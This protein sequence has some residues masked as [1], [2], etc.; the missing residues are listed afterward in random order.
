MEAFTI[1]YSNKSVAIV[2]CR[3]S[4]IPDVERGIMSLES[5]EFAIKEFLRALKMQVYS[6]LKTVGSAYNKPQPDLLNALS[7]S[8]NKVLVVYE[9]NRLT[10]NL[11]TYEEI[12]ELCI[13]N[14]HKIAVVTL[15]K[16]FN[17]S[18]SADYEQLKRHV[19]LANRESAEIGRRI[20][21]TYAYNKSRRPAW[22][23]MRNH[24]DQ[25]VN[26]EREI[27]VSRLIT[28]LSTA[29]SKVSEIRELLETLADP[30]KLEAEPFEI[31]EYTRGRDN[32]DT[33]V[34][35]L[36]CEMTPV[37]IA[38]TLNV[39]GIRR[40]RALWTSAFVKDIIAVERPANKKRK[41]G[42][43]DIDDLC[44][45]FQDV[46]PVGRPV[47]DIAPKAEWMCIWYDPAFG[48]PPNVTL[49]TGMKLPEVATQI[50]LP[51]KKN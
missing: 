8:K 6:V 13:E 51:I 19:E 32:V 33:V 17:L 11:D 26:N 4:R 29:G 18:V 34:T 9:P 44:Q 31:V 45:G 50:Y 7:T 25:V 22:G 37:Q 47:E 12:T 23:L 3:L 16:V 49:P 43:V 35:E 15:N 41:I 48:L 24:L 2:Y 39:Y 30:A 46:L 38:N 5:Q 21:R 42:E 28:K 40:R 20:S 14:N 1:T 27:S 10:R 36:P